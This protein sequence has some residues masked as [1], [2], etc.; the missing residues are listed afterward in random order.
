MST[1]PWGKVH[2]VVKYIPGFSFVN[3]PSHGGFR[4]TE[5]VLKF[6]TDDADKVIKLGGSKCGKYIFFE[7]DCAWA[8]LLDNS[9]ELLN[10]VA[11]IEKR[12]V[13]KFKEVVKHTSRRWFKEFYNEKV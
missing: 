8:L 6:H 10:I 9:P 3:T 12:D 13:I 7:E 2:S 4:I 5:K 11:E 1:S